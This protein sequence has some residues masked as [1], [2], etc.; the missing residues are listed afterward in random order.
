MTTPA[1]YLYTCP[2]CGRGCNRLVDLAPMGSDPEDLACLECASELR[3]PEPALEPT[4]ETE[5]PF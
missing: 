5:C 3:Q 1:P 4:R 2:R